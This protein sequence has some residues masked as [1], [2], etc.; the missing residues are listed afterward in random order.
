MT[1]SERPFLPST[2]GS[3][4][5]AKFEQIV[6]EIATKALMLCSAGLMTRDD[7]NVVLNGRHFK[8]IGF[9]I[10]CEFPN[11]ILSK[12]VNI[13][14]N[15]YFDYRFFAIFRATQDYY[16]GRYSIMISTKGFQ[17]Y[18]RTE[19]AGEDVSKAYW[20]LAVGACTDWAVRP[21][22][23]YEVLEN[24][25]TEMLVECEGKAPRP[26]P[27]YEKMEVEARK[28]LTSLENRTWAV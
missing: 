25:L 3:N 22:S 27:D 1:T 9:R 4:R 14:S 10:S 6:I 28:T 2:S 5:P 16:L 21:S 23:M 20:P 12:Y 13:A 17:K 11:D 7:R 8:A 19:V 26:F 24:T 18:Y 15:R